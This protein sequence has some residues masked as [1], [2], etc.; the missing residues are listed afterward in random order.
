MNDTLH[1]LAHYVSAAVGRR[2]H[3]CAHIVIQRSYSVFQ[4]IGEMF[5]PTP[6]VGSPV[7]DETPW[8]GTSPLGRRC[9]R[10]DVFRQILLLPSEMECVKSLGTGTALGAPFSNSG[11]EVVAVARFRLSSSRQPYP[12]VG[13]S[14]ESAGLAVFVECCSQVMHAEAVANV[15]LQTKPHLDVEGF[16]G[17]FF[18]D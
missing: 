13:H 11:L 18:A 17:L 16:L 2:H 3:A 12:N 9:V 8:H 15:R 4:P 5:P 10:Q 14:E 7:C 6:R 1:S